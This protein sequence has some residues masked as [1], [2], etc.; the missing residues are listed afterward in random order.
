MSFSL[1]KYTKS[2][3]LHGADL[4]E[5]KAVRLTING[6]YEHTFEQ[7][8][9]TRPVLV[10]LEM[11]QHLACNKTQVKSLLKH[12]PD[13]G[14]DPDVLVGKEILLMAVPSTF[15]GKPTISIGKAPATQPTQPTPDVEMANVSEMPF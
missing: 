13:A 5:G 10:F 4:P 15:E 7:T 8:K 2:K 9:D 11:A 6:V 3:W 1:G 12:W 14:D